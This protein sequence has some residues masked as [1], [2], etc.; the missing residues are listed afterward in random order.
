MRDLEKKIFLKNFKTEAVRSDILSYVRGMRSAMALGDNRLVAL[1][2]DKEAIPCF[3]DYRTEIC[4]LLMDHCI[5]QYI[6]ESRVPL[7]T[8]RSRWALHLLSS[9]VY[10]TWIDDNGLISTAYYAGL[11]MHPVFADRYTS[12]KYIRDYGV[13]PIRKDFIIDPVSANLKYAVPETTGD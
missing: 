7:A 8:I 12:D 11:F 6:V 4:A 5:D 2:C 1:A 10:C 13:W 9:D 3:R